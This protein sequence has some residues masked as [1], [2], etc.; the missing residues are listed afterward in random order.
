MGRECSSRGHGE[1]VPGGIRERHI[2]VLLDAQ[3]AARRRF[4]IEGG[5][6]H[7]MLDGHALRPPIHEDIKPAPSP[8]INELTQLIDGELDGG[9]LP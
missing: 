4:A 1:R 2:R 8:R 3:V 6:E 9:N 7:A 5:G